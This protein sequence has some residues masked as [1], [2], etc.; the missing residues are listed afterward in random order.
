MKTMVIK[1]NI[2]VMKSLTKS[3]VFV[4]SVL[5]CSDETEYFKLDWAAQLEMLQ[6]QLQLWVEVC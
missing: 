6:K 4:E 1:E 3:T 5:R 2:Q